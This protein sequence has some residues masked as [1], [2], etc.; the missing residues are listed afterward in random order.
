MAEFYLHLYRV[1][2]A[3]L[4]LSIQISGMD[5]DYVCNG[6]RFLLTFTFD[7]VRINYS[8]RKEARCKLLKATFKACGRGG[9]PTV[10]PYFF[11]FRALC[12]LIFNPVT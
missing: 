6:E 12:S 2:S 3:M 8:C 9:L 4:L 5:V 1:H 10:N 11:L 7:F